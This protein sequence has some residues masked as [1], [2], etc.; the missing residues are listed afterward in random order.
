MALTILIVDND[1]VN[2]FVLKNIIHRNYAEAEVDLVSDGLEALN[3][4]QE[5]EQKGDKFPDVV[6]L[7]IYLPAM[8]G[9]EF[10]DHYKER[11]AHKPTIIFVISN[12]FKKEDQQK[13]NDYDFVRGFITKPLIYNNIQFIIDSYLK[14][15]SDIYI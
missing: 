4:L 13:A 1:H 7:D 9:F 8:N 14:E 5:L 3:H 15:G 11:F 10:L 2:S 6:L 12:S